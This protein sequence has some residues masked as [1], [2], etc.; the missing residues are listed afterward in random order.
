MKKLDTA[1]PSTLKAVRAMLTNFIQK[2]NEGTGL[3]GKSSLISMLSV[4][5]SE[6]KKPVA[7]SASVNLDDLCRED[8]T[9]PEPVIIDEAFTE[10]KEAEK[11]IAENLTVPASAPTTTP[12]VSITDEEIDAKIASTLSSEKRI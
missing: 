2:N 11:M 8:V 6:E 7:P 4:I 10:N 3:N 1:Q 9:E 12:K 5:K